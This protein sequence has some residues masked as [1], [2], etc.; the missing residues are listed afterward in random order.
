MYR[1]IVLA[2]CF[3]LSGA[4]AHSA[5][6]IGST[7][8]YTGVN[9]L[10]VGYDFFDLTFVD[11]NSSSLN[12]V[13]GNGDL[14]SLGLGSN[15]AAEIATALETLANTGTFLM[16]SGNRFALVLGE[17]DSLSIGNFGYS[18]AQTSGNVA[19]SGPFTNSRSFDFGS[20]TSF[21]VLTSDT[22]PAVVSLP[23]S[24]FLLLGSLGGLSLVSRQKRKSA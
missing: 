1:K 10:Q 13:F 6:L 12:D 19:S 14:S 17:V 11:T 7:D 15:L 4:T 22:P 23:A 5:T 3:V 16:N 18:V 21:V 20:I 9:D 2:A 24:V 8:A